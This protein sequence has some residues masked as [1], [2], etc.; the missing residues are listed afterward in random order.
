MWYLQTG[1]PLVYSYGDEFFDFSRP[2]VLKLLFSYEKGWLLYTPAALISFLGFVPLLKRKSPGSLFLAAFWI[3][4]IYLSSCWW[5]WDYTSRFS[6][7]I[8]IDFL[9]INAVMLGAL[10]QEM[11]MKSPGRRILVTMLCLT[12]ALNLLQYFQCWKWVYPNGPVTRETYWKYFFTTTPMASVDYLAE[13]NILRRN[14]FCHG[15]ES[16]EGWINPGSYT[17]AQ[18]HSGRYSAGSGGVD[19]ITAGFDKLL[20]PL[21]EGKN[22]EMIITAWVFSQSHH[23]GVTLVVD[24]LANGLSYFYQSFPLDPYLRRGRWTSVQFRAMVPRLQTGLDHVRVYF[25]N[26]SPRRTA[27]I[28]DVCVELLSLRAGAEPVP[29]VVSLPPDRIPFIHTVSNDMEDDASGLNSGA[30]TDDLAMTGRRSSRIDARNPYSEGYRGPMPAGINLAH[31][32]IKVSAC[33]HTDADTSSAILVADFRDRGTSYFYSPVALGPSL[34]KEKWICVESLINMPPVVLPED[35]VLIYFW[36]PSKKEAVHVDD[37][38]IDFLSVTPSGI[39]STANIDPRKILFDTAFFHEMEYP[40]GWK[41]E[42]TLSEERP[43]FGKRSCRISSGNPFSVSLQGLPENYMKGNGVIRT[44][45]Y[46]YSMVKNSSAVLVVDFRRAK[47]SY[48]YEPY[49]MNMRSRFKEWEYIEFVAPVPGGR[50]PGDE[51]FIY[52]WNASGDE[53]IYIDDMS[54]EFITLSDRTE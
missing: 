42:A 9:A 38:R 46:V 28:D 39:R 13:G 32:E 50:L 26:D 45:A 33:I 5:I 19:T 51:V 15:M 44:G 12:V 54:V 47:E 41:N 20:K 18:A 29:A 31:P 17:D 24:Y 6:Q 49:Y 1:R 53:V 22:A 4:F 34:S 14:A 7:R 43:L 25:I 52:F 2:R 3:V 23:P 27:F 40:E 35:E 36:N 10:L 37:L 16:D 8:F 48:A 30:L 21:M 11:R